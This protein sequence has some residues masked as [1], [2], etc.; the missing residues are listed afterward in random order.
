MKLSDFLNF[1]SAR[2]AEAH[3]ETGKMDAASRER[4]N[5]QI[6]A[7]TPGKMLT[8]EVVEKNGGEV[9]IK[10]PGDLFMNARLDQDVNVELGKLLTFE[11][12]NNGSMLTLS[13]LFANTDASDNVYKALQMA[14]IPI[15]DTTVEMTEIMMQKGMSID[16]KS[17]QAIFKDLLANPGASIEDVIDLHKLG[18]AVNED[19]LQQIGNY[20]ELTHQ[21][22]NGMADVIAELPAV[23]EQLLSEKGPEEAVKLYQEIMRLFLPDTEQP[24]TAV[25]TEESPVTAVFSD[26]PKEAVVLT[27][28]SRFLLVEDGM[29]E[30][31]TPAEFAKLLSA[32]PKEAYPGLEELVGKMA[33]EEASPTEVL[34]AFAALS[35]SRDEDILRATAN[36]MKQ[37]AF[38]AVLKEAMQEQ[39][40]L[41]PE[42]GMNGKDVDEVYHRLERQLNG[43]KAAL[44][45]SG[46]TDSGAMRSV[47]N[48]SQNV[49]FINQM[50]QMYT[51]VQLPLKL[52]DRQANGELYVFTNKRSLAKKDG[53]VSAL[54]H[55][56]MENLGMVDVYVAL[57]N[58][59]VN[60]RFTVR[61][62]EVLLFLNDHMD[63]LTERLKKKGYDIKCEMSIKEQGDEQ[64]PVDRILGTEK[65]AAVMMQYGFDVRA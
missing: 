57:Q 4:L 49:D 24:Q 19:N 1:S 61:D 32:L 51:Y 45:E 7:L 60:T 10:L 62:D 58:E 14:N 44:T 37:P 65:N 59:K 39:W 12:K 54:L 2:M 6:R 50:N 43:I 3:S 31:G 8:G 63:I 52:Q 34:Q 26:I 22:T 29:K 28:E 21:L 20:K 47:T 46:S 27:E 13:P 30:A 15:N 53:T 56:D 48:L 40:S 18:I 16:S 35:E 33:K 42:E 25:F 41:K 23:Y 9:R 5:R 17:L 55:L 36:L 64:T 38:E 11:V